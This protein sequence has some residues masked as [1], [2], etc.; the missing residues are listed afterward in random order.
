MEEITQ[1]KEEGD[2]LIIAHNYQLPEVQDAADFLGDSL[3]LARKAGK[4]EKENILFCGVRFMAESAKIISPEKNIYIPEPEAGCPMADMISA[5]DVREMRKKYPEHVFVAY[6]NTSAEVKAEVDICCTSA[7]ALDIV[8]SLKGKK[9]FFL[10][11]KN[12]GNWVK[13]QSSADVTVWPGFCYVHNRITLEDLREGRKAHPE[14]SAMVHPEAPIDVLEKADAVLS[15]GQMIRYAAESGHD[16]F[17]VG[18]EEGM[19]YRLQTLFPQKKFHMMGRRFTCENMKKI[20]LEKMAG[21]M[22]NRENSIELTDDIIRK[23]AD[24]LHRMLQR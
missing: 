19:I 16:S 18:T 6:V 20:T 14:A 2:W 10:P 21:T 4:L 3:E 17:L 24:S 1:L 9:I 11:D 15:T 22:R 23:A 8:E 13:K 7:N 12:L 5:S